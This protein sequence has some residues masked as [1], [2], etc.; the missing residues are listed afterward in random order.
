MTDQPPFS[1]PAPRTWVS[2]EI[3]TAPDLRADVSN[4]IAFALQKPFWYGTNN[5]GP[6]WSPGEDG[7]LSF[8]DLYDNW[9]GHDAVTNLSN[10]YSQC[11]GW[12]LCQ[13]QVPF[14]YNGAQAEF[15]CGFSG[16]SSGVAFSTSWGAACLNGSGNDTAVAP[17]CHDLIWMP[18]SGAVD[19]SG[20]F[21][22]CIA[23]NGSAD[24]VGLA[25]ST[26]S[27]PTVS[28]R[29]VAATTGTTGLTVPAN[30]AWPVPPAYIT[31]A[32]MNAQ[33]RDTVNYLIYPP[34][35]KAIYTAGTSTIPSQAFP[36]GTIAPLGTVVIDNYGGFSTS[37][38][39]YTAPVAGN[40]FC[41]GQVNFVTA[42]GGGS[43]SAGLSVNAGTI[44]WGD[45]V[46]HGGSGQGA[47]SVTRRLRLT[48]GQ[49]VALY[50]QQNSG[51][52][53]ELHTS[54]AW[55]TRLI[56]VWEGA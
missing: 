2:G 42:S 50:A 7:P 49:T 41:A 34:I 28:V 26:S 21:I 53:V 20:D 24:S 3:I 22:K 13:M 30:P 19:G 4:S 43:Y 37:A 1:V 12:Y 27:F 9:N 51:S 44:G 48:A 33:V 56:V 32:D 6:T 35:C 55:Q 45:S 39:T 54:T 18:V 46:A 11:P 15:A 14:V 47:A 31:S 38:Y 40:Y 8:S 52:S 23:F 25:D 29:F 36:S 17:Q 16:V 5:S 10:Y